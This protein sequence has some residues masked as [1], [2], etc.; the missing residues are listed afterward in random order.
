[1]SHFWLLFRVYKFIL[2]LD[3]R[4][5]DSFELDKRLSQ[6]FYRS[7]CYFFYYF[8]ILLYNVVQF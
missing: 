6:K 1:M 7:A 8:I 4:G 3:L 2:F 5:N